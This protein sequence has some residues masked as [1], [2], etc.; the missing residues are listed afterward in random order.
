MRKLVVA[1]GSLVFA[2]VA[3]SQQVLQ[4]VNPDVL[5]SLVFDARPESKLVLTRGMP[6]S[7]AGFRAPA[8]FTLIGSGV[9]GHNLSTVVAYKTM[10]A[11][12]QALDNWMAFLAAEG[13]KREDSLQEPL[14]P[15]GV[16]Q[17]SLTAPVCRDGERRN[18]R[19]QDIGGIRYATILGFETRPARACNT[20]L[21][22][23]EQ[24]NPMAAMQAAQANMP[25]LSF[26]ESARVAGESTLSHSGTG[27]RT[28][29]SNSRI[30][31][32]DTAATLAAQ[33]TR[34]LLNQ[35]WRMDAEWKGRLSAGSTWM[36]NADDGK[37]YRGT[38]EILS[39]DDGIY[40]VG[41]SVV[42][43]P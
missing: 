21:P 10:L 31:S 33:L 12:Q 40:D 32:P 14:P 26:P 43:M 28:S 36:R 42:T 16:A 22:Q 3:Q 37:L 17:V 6:D 29:S 13:W 27:G 39:V 30:Q 34:Q 38:L 18:L 19:V 4:C 41:F 25:Q 11:G 9:R 15:S 5:N 2:V 7:V 8:G 23:A 1:L 35:R 20:P 24:F